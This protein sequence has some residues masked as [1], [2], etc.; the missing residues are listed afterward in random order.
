VLSASDNCG[1]A[2]VSPSVDLFIEDPCNGYS[3]TY[4]WTATDECNNSTSVTQTFNVLADDADPTFDTSPNAIA[5][6]N[7]GDALPTQQ[8]L[9]AS[10]NCGNA[11]VLPSVDLFIE[12]P[13]NGYLVTYR[14]TATDDCNNSTFITQFFNV[15]PDII[16]PTFDNNPNTIADVNCDDPLPTQQIL[17]AS[18]NCGNASVLPSVDPFTE[19]LCNGYSVTYRWTATDECNNSTFI[20][21]TF[22][23]LPDETNPSFTVPVTANINCGEDYTDLTLTGDVTNES[24]NC[25]NEVS[26]SG[27]REASFADDLSNLGDCSG[28]I[29]RTWTLI[30][31]CGNEAILTQVINIVPDNIDPT[32][33]VPNNITID[34]DDD[35]DDLTL[36]G[37]VTDENDNC[38]SNVS[39]TG[40]TVATYTDDT[41]DLDN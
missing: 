29:L 41:S 5:D 35:I 11:S 1:N 6:I 31:I 12:D 7:C 28:S 17:T 18:D 40:P 8:T 37:D 14:W 22:N 24:D 25:D 21:Q 9:T 34:C 23:V 2:S 38:D 36:T 33:T 10:D 20:T 39:N 15:L 13:C 26:N 32:F 19:D 16:D 4:R 3:V 30:D 27:I